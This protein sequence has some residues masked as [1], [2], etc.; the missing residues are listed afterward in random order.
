M[1]ATRKERHAVDSFVKE[2]KANADAVPSKNVLDAADEVCRQY[3]LLGYFYERHPIYKEIIEQMYGRRWLDLCRDYLN[4]Y[5]AQ[6]REERGHPGHFRRALYL[7]DEIE[8]IFPVFQPTD[9]LSTDDAI[10][11]SWAE[12]TA[13]LGSIRKS[14][15]GP[16]RLNVL[17]SGSS[18]LRRLLVM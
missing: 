1:E 2:Q 7:R 14:R 11:V 4:K 16:I 5:I 17:I 12:S 6:A 10:P 15:R 3:D 9:L 8:R 18:L 13:T